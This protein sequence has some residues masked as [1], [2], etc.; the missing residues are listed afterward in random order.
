MGIASK[1]LHLL[2]QEVVKRPLVAAAATS[3]GASLQVLQKC[4]FVVD[5]FA[6][7]LPATDSQNAKKPFLF[8]GDAPSHGHGSNVGTSTGHHLPQV[9]VDG[10]SKKERDHPEHQ[11]GHLCLGMKLKRTDYF[12]SILDSLKV[13][14]LFKPGRQAR[15]RRGE[16]LELQTNPLIGL[17]L[18]N[19]FDVTRPVR[20]RDP[21]TSAD[22]ALR[23]D[24]ELRN[25]DSGERPVTVEVGSL[26]QIENLLG[27]LFGSKG[28]RFAAGE[29]YG[30]HLVCHT[31]GV[32]LLA[33]FFGSVRT[34]LIAR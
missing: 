21:D 3:N 8:Y 5:E 2:L 15:H 7:R 23:L 13:P 28:E 20:V 33:H 6:S 9:P 1:A 30:L 22:D 18:D 4:G 19:L 34:N 10:S 24:L 31:I 11:P 32:T 14:R 26:R 27:D 12:R 29:N 25:L 16:F 17:P